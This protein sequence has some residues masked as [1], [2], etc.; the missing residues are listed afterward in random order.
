MP[1]SV[2]PLL[3]IALPLLLAAP[4]HADEERGKLLYDNPG[5]LASILEIL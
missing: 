2:R 3:L 1:A 4:A 5:A